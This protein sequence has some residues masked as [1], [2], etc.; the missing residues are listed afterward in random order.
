[1]ESINVT[2]AFCTI[3]NG[4]HAATLEKKED[5]NHP[6]IID[7]YFYHGEPHFTLNINSFPDIIRS[8]DTEIRTMKLAD[9]QKKD[10]QHCNCTESK[11]NKRMVTL[12][13]KRKNHTVLLQPEINDSDTDIYFN[14]LYYTYNNFHGFSDITGR[15]ASA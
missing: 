15:S 10:K 1:M 7:H 13:A 6:D 9:H 12:E 8:S 11:R 3:C 14:D 2:V 4:Y 5:I